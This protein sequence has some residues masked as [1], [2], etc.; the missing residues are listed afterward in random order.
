MALTVDDLVS[1]HVFPELNLIAG[2]QG[3]GN[4]IRWVNLMEILDS[5]GTVSPGEL[6]F[7]T[8]YGL[9]EEDSFRNLIPALAEQ[10]VSGIVFQTGLYIDRVPSWLLAQ[11]DELGF[12]VL[13]ISRS[14][15]FSSILHTMMQL[16]GLEQQRA[17]NDEARQQIRSF[18]EQTVRTRGGEFF[19]APDP[20]GEPP[21]PEEHCT[22]LLLLEPVNFT[23]ASLDTWKECL[24]QIRSFIQSHV[25]ACAFQTLPQFKQ[26]FLAAGPA[27]GILSMLRELNTK[28]TLLS[29]LYGT[30]WYIG[31]EELPALEKC[32]EVMDR[33]IECVST[34]F[35]IQARRGVCAY[36]DI[37]FL[38]TLG[39]MHQSSHSSV[40]NNR[41]LQQ[42][43]SHDR[44]SGTGYVET[45]RVYLANSCNVTQTAKRLF[46]HRHTLLKRLE[47]IREIGGVNLDD[48][49]ARTY[50]SV[51]L[52]FHDYFIY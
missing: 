48:Y 29:E 11:A 26:V 51:S 49:Y 47:K 2:H 13:T 15:T 37:D 30:N 33:T 18:L 23:Y 9:Q 22:W 4:E 7:T 45:L 42:L 36:S 1:R 41:P 19:P 8:G 27:R 39:F 38:K 31:A 20:E 35:F 34:L 28:L 21:D 10:G 3:A 32:S 43:L 50:M 17:W 12:P 14:V 5:P 40:L 44:T 6:L 16:I 25:S 46:V 52:L 24:G